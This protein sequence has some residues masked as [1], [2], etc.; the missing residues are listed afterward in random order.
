MIIFKLTAF[1]GPHKS[2][3]KTS[4]YCETY[5]DEKKKDGHSVHIYVMQCSILSTFDFL[6]ANM[7]KHDLYQPYFLPKKVT[8]D[9]TKITTVIELNGIR[10]ADRRGVRYPETAKDNPT[11]LYASESANAA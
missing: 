2:N 11:T 6:M 8:K 7:A 1:A 4:R 10:I 3:Q 5:A 9:V